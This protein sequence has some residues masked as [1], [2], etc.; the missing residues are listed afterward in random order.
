[1][2]KM[3]AVG[4]AAVGTKLLTQARALGI[5]AYEGYGLSEGASVQTLNLPGADRPGSV[6]R[7]LPHA[8]LRV[9]ADGEVELRD[10]MFLGYLGDPR[11]VPDWWPSGDMGHID[12]A[13]FLY[14]SGRKKNLLITGFGRNVAPEWVETALRGEPAIGQAVVYGEGM[15]ALCAVLW[16]SR[17]DL[18]DAVLQ[19][20]V[21]AAN[22]GL[23]DYARV[24]LW[25][26]A[27]AD[28]SPET[29]LATTNGRPQRGAIW[30]A[31]EAALASP[32]TH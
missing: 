25:L 23:P 22:A 9:A 13:G 7:A 11:P 6:G 18:D 28:F 19:A 16:P 27:R 14:I 30:R 24:G 8:D 5:P 31:H 10:N 15:S 21:E 26:R 17:H 29:G 1:M 4:G 2:L 20:A 32:L 3:V 12:D